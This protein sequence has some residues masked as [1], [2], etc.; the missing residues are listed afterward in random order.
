MDGSGSQ[1]PTPAVHPLSGRVTIVTGASG[2]IGRAVALH[3]SSLGANLVVNYATSSAAADLLVAEINSSSSELRAIAVRAN[4]SIAAEV[5]SLFDEAEKAFASQVHILV[6]CA[7][8]L[9]PKYPTLH[10]TLEEDFDNIFQINA[11]GTFL[12]YKEAANRIKR[13]GGGRI[14]GFSSS[15]VASLRP[16]YGAYT[17]SKAAVEAMT[18][19]MAK[20]LK[21]TQI[22]VNCVAPGPIATDMF[23][24]GK[25]DEDVKKSVDMCPLNRLGEAKDLV[26]IVGLLATDA[27]EW[28]NGQTIRVNGGYV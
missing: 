20:E 12:C 16:G 14:I 5:K 22:T 24:A 28:I 21:G 4:V 15:L 18:S 2:G 19:V 1:N 17:A 26:G 9:D 3:L 6:N 10:N 25:T 11:K 27:G 23:F 13:G 7:G 8:V